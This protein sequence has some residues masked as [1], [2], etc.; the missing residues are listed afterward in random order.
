MTHTTKYVFTVVYVNFSFFPLE[1]KG[2]LGERTG[3][4]NFERK[5]RSAIVGLLHELHGY[6]HVL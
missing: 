5:Q 4:G 2:I 6:I 1:L 3:V